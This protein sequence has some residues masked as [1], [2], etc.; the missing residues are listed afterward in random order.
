[1]TEVTPGAD[2]TP[3]TAPAAASTPT[4]ESLQADVDKWK[5]L[6]RQN[7]STAKANKAAADELASIKAS[8]LSDQQRAEAAAQAAQESAQNA[9]A[10]LARYKVAA[11]K[12]V[13]V[14]LLTASDEAALTVQADALLKFVGDKSPVPDLGQGNRGAAA[15]QDPNSWIRANMLRN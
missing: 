14:E 2:G 13:P 1:M 12:G 8:Q 4:I 10:E 7:E 11:A 6:S 3:A 15:A 5:A 9:Q